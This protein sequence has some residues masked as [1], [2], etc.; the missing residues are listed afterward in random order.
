MLNQFMD[1]IK[2]L[3][4]SDVGNVSV[5]I[6]MIQIKIPAVMELIFWWIEL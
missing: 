3:S 2:T 5:K 1:S 4:T 6:Q